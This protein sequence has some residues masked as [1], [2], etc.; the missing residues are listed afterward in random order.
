MRELSMTYPLLSYLDM[1]N[2]PSLT[3]H[4][5]NN[6]IVYVFGTLWLSDWKYKK[7]SKFQMVM[8]INLPLGPTSCPKWRGVR[9]APGSRPRWRPRPLRIFS[10]YS[11]GARWSSSD[12]WKDLRSLGSRDPFTPD[13]LLIS[14]SWTARRMYAKKVII[15]SRN[16]LKNKLDAVIKTVIPARK[17]LPLNLKHPVT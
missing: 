3:V 17:C 4:H 15:L 11:R 7:I 13:F 6:K 1:D 2:F 10:V 16:K 9:P 14:R 5:H 8:I 12:V